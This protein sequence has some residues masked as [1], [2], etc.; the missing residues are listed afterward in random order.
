MVSRAQVRDKSAWMGRDFR[1]DNSWIVTLTDSQV[2]ELRGAAGRC[3][4]RGLAVTDVARNAS[5]AL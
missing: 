5:A 4:D 3:I 1:D 2:A